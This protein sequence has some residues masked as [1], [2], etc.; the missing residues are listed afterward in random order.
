MKTRSLWALG[1]IA[2]ILSKPNVPRLIRGE[3]LW[4]IRAKIHF[5]LPENPGLAF[6]FGP[7]PRYE[8]LREKPLVACGMPSP[9]LGKRNAVI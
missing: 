1:T 5:R 3:I 2:V 6:N 7:G 8:F 9:F 4:F